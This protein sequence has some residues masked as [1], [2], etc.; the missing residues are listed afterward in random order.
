MLAWSAKGPPASQPC[1]P[2]LLAP[3]SRVRDRLRGVRRSCSQRLD[4]DVVFRR[5]VV[6]DLERVPFRPWL[7]LPLPERCDAVCVWRTLFSRSLGRSDARVLASFTTSF[8]RRAKP[9]LFTKA[10]SAAPAAG[11]TRKRVPLDARRP[12]PC[13]A[14]ATSSSRSARSITYLEILWISAIGYRTSRLFM[15][16]SITGC[17]PSHDCPQTVHDSALGA[18]TVQV[19]PPGCRSGRV[20]CPDDRGVALR[21]EP[22]FPH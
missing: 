1:S 4:D 14:S 22:R 10:Y 9:S 11:R 6:L 15:K 7:P 19:A 20:R 2:P 17:V 13:A 3:R 21:R 18:P 8:V 5:E 12:L 16:E